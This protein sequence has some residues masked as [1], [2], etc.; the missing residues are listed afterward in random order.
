MTPANEIRIRD[1]AQPVL[2][3]VQAAA[4]AYAE[5]QPVAFDVDSFLGAAVEPTGL[6]DFCNDE[7]RAR[8]ALQCRAIEEDARLLLT[9]GFAHLLGHASH[10]LW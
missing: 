2:T 5:T 1:L 9:K 6:T 4:V 10:V 7:Y 3:S 8:L